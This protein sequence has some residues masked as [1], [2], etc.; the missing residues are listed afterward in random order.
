MAISDLPLLN[1]LLNTASAVFL[2]SG[3]LF[4]RN[5]KIKYHR[6]S[7]IAAFSASVLFLISYLV[8]HAHVGS[9]A[10]TGTGWT[11]PLYFS[12]LIT[13]SILAAAVPPLAIITL[14]RALR[15]RFDK[16]K[17]LARWTFPIWLYVSATGVMIYLLLYKL[18]SAGM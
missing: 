7:M 10:Y 8:Y 15:E 9:V 2:L 6:A 12:I 18:P 17:R 1:A 4:I 3:Y 14:S 11:R 16:H 13:H 5:K